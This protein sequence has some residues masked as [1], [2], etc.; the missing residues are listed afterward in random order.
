MGI[1]KYTVELSLPRKKLKK[2]SGLVFA[3]NFE[4][5]VRKMVEY[6]SDDLYAILYLRIISDEEVIPI[7]EEITRL[8]SEIEKCLHLQ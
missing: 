1:F 2:E 6:Y 5:A 8:T 4:D 7:P 3:E